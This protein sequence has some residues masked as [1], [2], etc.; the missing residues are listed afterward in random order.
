MKKKQIIIK[1]QHSK[2]CCIDGTEQLR[3]LPRD[4]FFGNYAGNRGKQN[5]YRYWIEMIC[6]DPSCDYLALIDSHL[7]SEQFLE[8]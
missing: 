2:N 6:D 1:K 4:M 7:L 5:S 3:F 8:N